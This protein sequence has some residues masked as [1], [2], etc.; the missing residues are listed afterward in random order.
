M[1]SSAGS[2]KNTGDSAAVLN[3]DFNHSTH[4]TQSPQSTQL[5]QSTQSTKLTLILKSI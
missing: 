3:I 4:S 5:T 1:A 2:R